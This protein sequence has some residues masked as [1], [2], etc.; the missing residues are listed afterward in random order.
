MAN[1]KGRKARPET[2][3]R[4]TPDVGFYGGV[5]T[6]EEIKDLETK[7]GAGLNDEIQMLRVVIRQ[8]FVLAHGVEDLDT[9]INALSALGISAW[10]LSGLLKS[11]EALGEPRD[12][13]VSAISAA[14]AQVQ[15]EL[16]LSI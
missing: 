11:Q 1:I 3:D 13:V 14:I 5:F 2:E 15:Q 9:A 10:R 4:Q 6:P 16:K 8:V 7:L 12:A